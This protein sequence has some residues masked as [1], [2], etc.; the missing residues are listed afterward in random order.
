MV[1]QLHMWMLQRRHNFEQS[2]TLLSEQTAAALSCSHGWCRKL[3][4]EILLT[5]GDNVLSIAADDACWAGLGTSAWLALLVLLLF[6]STGMPAVSK[7]CPACCLHKHDNMHV[8]KSSDAQADMLHELNPCSDPAQ[9]YNCLPQ[10]LATNFFSIDR[11]L[12]VSHNPPALS[13]NQHS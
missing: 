5:H 12:P 4:S 7:D 9:S 6:S 8:Q 13:G 1:S 11:S 10:V 2:V 3:D